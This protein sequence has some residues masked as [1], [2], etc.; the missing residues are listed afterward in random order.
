MYR[1]A[2]QD[3]AHAEKT[4][5]RLYCEKGHRRDAICAHTFRFRV[6]IL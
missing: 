1:I 5:G 4:A 2:R 3:V 6:L